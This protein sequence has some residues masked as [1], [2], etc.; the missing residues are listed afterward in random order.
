MDNKNNFTFIDLFAGI[1]GTRIGFE[2]AGGKC[3]FSSE[4]DKDA[5]KT[6]YENFGEIPKGD[7]T[8]IET[9]EIPEFD[10]L[11]AGFPCQPFSMIGKR[12]GF[13]HATQGTLFFEIVR[14]LEDKKPKAFLLEN[15]KGLTHHDKGNTFRIIKEALD[16]LG[17]HVYS[18]ILDAADFG[19]PQIRKRIY[20]VGFRKDLFNEKPNFKHPSGFSNEIFINQFLEEGI[21]DRPI[22]QHLQEK[23]I[24]KNDDGHPQIVDRNSR[25]KVKTLVA[26]YH[27]IQ[28]I[29]GTFVRDG[30]TGLRLLT[31]KECKAIM[32]FPEDFKVPVSRT[33][34]YRQFGNSVAV[35][36]V[37]AVAKEMIKFMI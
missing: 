15:V 12:E 6:Y 22:S 2:R 37:E 19:L 1:G 29:T 17:Y 13:K 10:I 28:R 33:Q 25:I 30:P 3:V 14:I 9:K 31:E 35:P 4:W 34:M 16:S 36:V 26:S 20:I 24:F 27:K 32:G 7:I 8:K 11:I 21:T 5:Q 23:Y 18:E